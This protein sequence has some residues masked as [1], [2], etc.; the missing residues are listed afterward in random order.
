[1]L[2]LSAIKQY[3][4]SVFNWF[5]LNILNWFYLNILTQPLKVLKYV[6]GTKKNKHI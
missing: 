5:Y 6:Y 1:M 4:L 3:Y 2:Y